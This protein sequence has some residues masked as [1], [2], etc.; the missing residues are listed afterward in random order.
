MGVYRWNAQKCRRP[1]S[2]TLKYQHWC[3]H[4]EMWILVVL[5]LNI[6]LV[7]SFF[8][9]KYM[10]SVFSAWSRGSGLVSFFASSGAQR[11][12]DRSAQR[13]WRSSYFW[14]E[15]LSPACWVQPCSLYTCD[16]GDDPIWS[17]AYFSPPRISII[18]TFCIAARLSCVK[19][20]YFSEECS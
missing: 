15:N 12:R 19:A 13:H 4:H 2:S 18:N 5:R 17:G 20:I 3:H 1:Q 11:V 14:G 16:Q 9:Q 8:G 10:T 7:L 6:K